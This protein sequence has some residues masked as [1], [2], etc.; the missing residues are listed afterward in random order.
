VPVKAFFAELKRRRVYRV[1]VVNA[2][3][4]RMRRATVLSLMALSFLVGPTFAQTSTTER[5]SQGEQ[6]LWDL[7]KTYFAY[8]ADREFE[9]LGDFW[10]PNFIGWPSHSPEPVGRDNSRQSLKDLTAELKELSVKLRPLAITIHGDV[11]VAH[12]YIDV[13]QEALDGQITEYSLRITHT[14]V[15]SDGRWRILGGMSAQ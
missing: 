10:H 4:H 11:A 9:A 12:Y 13:V 6:A 2:E 1:A 3:V 8:L 15:K 7:E 5:Q 14:W